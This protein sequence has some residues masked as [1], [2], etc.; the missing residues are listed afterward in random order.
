MAILNTLGH[1][2][3]IIVSYGATWKLFGEAFY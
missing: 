2:V 1:E 3:N